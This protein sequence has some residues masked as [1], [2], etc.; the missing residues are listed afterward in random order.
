[1]RR[2]HSG[3]RAPTVAETGGR[4]LADS[5]GLPNNIPDRDQALDDYLGD[6]LKSGVPP[7]AASKSA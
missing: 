6:A 2:G 1:M 4:Y 3:R 7:V 5:G